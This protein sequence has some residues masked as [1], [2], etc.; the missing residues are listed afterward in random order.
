MNGKFF[1]NKSGAVKTAFQNEKVAINA[2]VNVDSNGPV[3]LGAGVVGY[4]GWLAGYQASYDVQKNKLLK[5]NIAL[6][7]STT[8]FV[9]HTSV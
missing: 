1:R 5:N 3:L 4:Q 8:D 9:L 2:D 6:G 7:F